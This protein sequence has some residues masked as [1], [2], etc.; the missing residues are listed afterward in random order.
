MPAV[1]AP[2]GSIQVESI[3]ICRWVD[4]ELSTSNDISSNNDNNDSSSYPAL[5]PPDAAG[6]A[7]MNKII[8]AGSAFSEAGLSFLSGRNGRYWGIGSGQTAQQRT[9][10]ESALKRAIVD[11]INE[12]K[13]GPFLM[14]NTITLAD[15]AVYPFVKRYQLACREFCNG[16]DVSSVL[17]GVVGQWLDAMGQRPA[18]QITTAKDELLLKAYKQH[19]G[20]DFFDYDT[21]LATEL[22]PQNEEYRL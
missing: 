13:G 3:D 21:Y 11:P 16:Y 2:D 18:C 9:E 4:T 5:S 15:I 17:N 19:K 20:L 22:H 10:F 8:S 1:Q 7:R 6:K 14:G 12:N